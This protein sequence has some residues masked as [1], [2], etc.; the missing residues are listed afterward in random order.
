MADDLDNLPGLPRHTELIDGS[1]VFRSPQ[2]AFHSL[3]VSLLTHALR[4]DCPAWLRVA[5]GMTVTLGSHDRPEPDVSVVRAEA[6]TEDAEETGYQ[7]KDVL[8]VV[9]VV[10]PDSLQRDRE[11]KPRKYAQAGIPHFWRVE[12]AE[13]RRPVVYVFELDP[14]TET[15]V[16]TGIFHDR[17]KVVV[18]FEIDIDLTE[19]DTL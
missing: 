4:T 10:S 17:L 16:P 2:Q 12:K 7:A 14:A 19:I 18:P 5:C 11:T 15:Y 9:E 6:V 1:L 3:A 13:G 8:L